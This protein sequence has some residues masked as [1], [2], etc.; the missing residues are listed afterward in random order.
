MKNIHNDLQKQISTQQNS[1]SLLT[2]KGR[3]VSICLKVVYLEVL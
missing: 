3:L 1:S 2:T